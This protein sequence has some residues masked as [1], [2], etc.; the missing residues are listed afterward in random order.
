ML[1]YYVVGL[2]KYIIF[3][4]DIPII[5]LKLNYKYYIVYHLLL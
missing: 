3:I 1:V 4:L 2:H 5:K